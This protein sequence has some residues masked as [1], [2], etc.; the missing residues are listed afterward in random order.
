VTFSD[1]KVAEL[2]NAKFVAAWF[3]RSPGFSNFDY[4]AEEEIYKHSAEAYTTKN[5]CTFVLA[6]DRRV[7]TYVAGHLA[8]AL[9]IAFLESA[10]AMREA[11][12]DERMRLKEGGLDAVK[13]LHAKRAARFEG[14]EPT[15]FDIPA[16][17]GAK[18]D[19][20]DRCGNWLRATALYF[21]RLHK[22]WSLLPELPTLDSIR[23]A[24][25]YGNDFTEEGK[26]GSK[27]AYDETLPRRG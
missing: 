5:I 7:F 10:L 13:A 4:K 6:P 18:H 8:P 23:F 17:R 25:L 19:H 12:F 14:K 15:A 1:R 11:A 3:N 9:F 24:Y 16:Y 27:I 20:T 22:K 2:V 26:D 21:A